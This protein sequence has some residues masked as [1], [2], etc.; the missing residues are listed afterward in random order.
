MQTQLR[1]RPHD[2]IGAIEA[3]YDVDSDDQRWLGAILKSIHPALDQGGGV[4]GLFYEGTNAGRVRFWGQE[5]HGT[6]AELLK[7]TLPSVTGLDGNE[8]QHMYLQCPRVMATASEI[9]GV[10]RVL[11]YAPKTPLGALG[12]ADTVGIKCHEPEGWGVMFGLPVRHLVRI[13]DV[14][15]GRWSRFAAHVT[16]ALRI[17]RRLS[18]AEGRAVAPDA[19]LTSGGAVSHAE[20]GAQSSQSHE[21]LAQAVRAR[22]SARGP[23]RR[24]D[25]EEAIGLWQAL[26]SGRWSLLDQVDSDGR[27]WV[28][29]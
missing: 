16:A 17:R 27:R 6:T 19:V 4:L 10:E 3:T 13:D 12:F 22:E 18:A 1:D 28:E 11:E 15:E 9:L 23:L 20:K 14:T 7:A 25:P 8:L 21:L 29:S 5:G 26:V 24:T 2:M